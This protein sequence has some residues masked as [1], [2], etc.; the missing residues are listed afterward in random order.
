MLWLPSIRPK[1]GLNF[2]GVALPPR[3]GL[4]VKVAVVTG[5]VAGLGRVEAI[6]LALSG[7]TV[8]VDDIVA[9]LEMSPE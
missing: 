1:L 8:V 2:S 6:G 3:L 7:A 9:A 4:S 5:A